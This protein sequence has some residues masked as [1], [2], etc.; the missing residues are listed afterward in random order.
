MIK[1]Y[2]R[3]VR[4]CSTVNQINRVHIAL[5]NWMTPL[6]WWSLRNEL[7]QSPVYDF[8]R[9]PR[10]ENAASVLD[11]RHVQRT[12]VDTMHKMYEKAAS[13]VAQDFMRCRLGRHINWYKSAQGE[14]LNKTLVICFTGIAQRMMIPLP[15]FLQHIDATDCDVVMIRYPRGKGYR[16]GLEGVA[17]GFAATVVKLGEILPVQQYA[18]TVTIGVSGG[19]LPAVMTALRLNFDAALSFSGGHPEDPRWQEASGP[20][21]ATLLRDFMQHTNKNVQVFLAY[22]ADSKADEHAAMALGQLLPSSIIRIGD[23]KT[24]V[25]HVSLYPLLIWGQLSRFL[26][27]TV[28]APRVE[29]DVLF[30]IQNPVFRARSPGVSKQPLRP[31]T[32][33]KYIGIGINKTGTTS[34]GRCFDALELTPVAEPRSQYINYIELSREIFE[35]GNFEPALQVAKYFRAFQDRPWNV[36]NM[37]QHLDRKFEGSYF[38]LTERDPDSWWNSVEHWLTVVHKGDRPKQLRYLH[39]LR[40]ER[41]DKPTFVDAYTRYN[42]EVKE[43]FRGNNNLLVMNLEAGAGWNEICAFLELPVPQVEFPH[44]NKQAY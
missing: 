6:Q 31:L 15:V 2:Q 1:L 28:L 38:I 42:D 30:P 22:G 27:E 35:H 34:L 41:M 19:G 23:E 18:R 9:Q 17:D 4:G 32:G 21:A 12:W 20:S 11:I 26:R 43:Y 37:Y 29:S 44:A 8:L 3:L 5:E 13:N 40:V 24:P 16:Y 10:N 33:P 25:G 7:L 14:T 39:H 36:W